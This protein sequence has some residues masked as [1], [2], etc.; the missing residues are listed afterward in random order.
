[1]KKPP[2]ITLTLTGD[3]WDITADQSVYFGEAVAA[4]RRSLG[5]MEERLLAD[6]ALR[7]GGEEGVE[8]EGKVDLPP[9]WSYAD[10]SVHPEAD[11]PGYFRSFVDPDSIMRTLSCAEDGTPTLSAMDFMRRHP[12]PA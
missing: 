1:M 6:P 3:R 10:E 8:A 5:W 12:V 7:I 2:T 9:G 4:V 11:G